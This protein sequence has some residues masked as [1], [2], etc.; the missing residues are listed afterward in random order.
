[1]ANYEKS[2]IK[3]TTT[4]LTKLKSAAKNNIKNNKGWNNIK[5]NKG[6]LSRRIAS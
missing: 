3:L 2:R 4:Q 6:K 1:M 5:N